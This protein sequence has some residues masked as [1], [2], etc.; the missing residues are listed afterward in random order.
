[1]LSSGG[2][3]PERRRS[4][5]TWSAGGGSRYGAAASRR[6]ETS[7]EVD[8]HAE[9]DEEEREEEEEYPA[10]GA[11]EE[12]D[13]EAEQPEQE[14]DED[15]EEEDVFGA[16]TPYGDD[17]TYESFGVRLPITRAIIREHLLNNLPLITGTYRLDV[18]PPQ[19]F[20]RALTRGVTLTRFHRGEYVTREETDKE[21]DD[22]WVVF[23]G[24]LVA[25]RA[26]RRGEED[27]GGGAVEA[28]KIGGGGSSDSSSLVVA[29]LRE[30]STFGNG[31][32]F[33]D[34]PGNVTVVAVTE[35]TTLFH[36]T[37]KCMS[38]AFAAAPQYEVDAIKARSLNKTT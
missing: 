5:T 22:C 13:T 31:A 1:M 28:V 14:E 30:G 15:E 21:S 9:L 2:G 12:E 3:V 33:S 16:A 18:R 38:D 19:S 37:A 34:V 4:T 24:G 25:S 35:T 23:E 36:I 8:E 11:A 10:E 32:L 20:M 29:E 26:K 7:F 27:G 17:F 6:L